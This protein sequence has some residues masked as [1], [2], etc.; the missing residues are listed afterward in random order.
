MIRRNDLFF[1]IGLGIFL[2]MLIFFLMFGITDFAHLPFKTRSL[3]LIAICAN[4]LLLR[5]YRKLRV[6]QTSNG[7]IY[8]TFFLAIVWI[9]WFYDE[10]AH[11][12]N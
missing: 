11:E 8:A 9:I 10:I 5:F 4:L 1:G 3:S 7:V 6:L 12:I 2:P